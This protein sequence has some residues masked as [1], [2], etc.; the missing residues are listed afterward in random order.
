MEKL[1]DFLKRIGKSNIHIVGVTG[2]EG[3]GIL[4]L[5]SDFG[6]KNI[7]AHDFISDDK[8]EKN[9]KIWH[10]GIDTD[11][12]QKLFRRFSQNL[13][14]VRFYDG[15]DYLK[16]IEKADI[17]FVS[18]SWKLYSQN[19]PLFD[20]K[21]KIPFYS[22]TRIYLDFAKAQVVAV[23]GTVGKGS[24][25]SLLTEI[26]RESGRNSFFAGNETWKVQ[27]VDKLKRMKPDDFLVL[28]VSHRQLADGF[29]RPPATVVVTNLFP[30]HL[31]ELDWESYLKLKLTL[32]RRQ[33]KEGNSVINY[34]NDELRRQTEGLMS[35][36]F[37]YSLKDRNMNTESIRKI[38][39]QILNIKSV[40]YPEN[41]LAAST[42]AKI[43]GITDNTIFKAIVKSQGLTA[44]VEEIGSVNGVK[45]ID[46]IKSTTPWA[47]LAA[48]GK[49]KLPQ[50]LIA[51]GDMKGIDYGEFWQ[52]IKKSGIKIILL[53]SEMAGNAPDDITRAENLEKAVVCGLKSLPPDGTLLVSPAAANFYS[54]FVKGKISLRKIVTSLLPG[55]RVSGD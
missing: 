50:V 52:K 55:G 30:N 26:F 37:Y 41:V 25:A 32:V 31:D 17:I 15:R 46:D 13:G 34:D 5:L 21:G 6:A 35:K 43:Y 54:L 24:T 28:E 48:V 11:I 7:T 4:N 44:R 47:T 16:D 51:G 12:R 39:D 3:S 2:S 9:F 18:Q 22:L 33:G 53:P 42:T 19:R 38:Y 36:R 27:P 8:L 1:G 40:H 23:T 45:I 14:K 10:K 49:Y 20:L 29:S